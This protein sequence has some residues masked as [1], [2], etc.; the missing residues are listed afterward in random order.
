MLLDSKALRNLLICTAVSLALTSCA[1]W[2]NRYRP[3]DI[4]TNMPDVSVLVRGVQKAIDD[5][6]KHEAWAPND[7]FTSKNAICEAKRKNANEHETA[8]CMKAYADARTDC[9]KTMGVASP[10][11][12]ADYFRQ[13]TQ[14]CTAAAD[15]DPPE[16]AQ[17]KLIGPPRISEA[18]LQLTAV[19]ESGA[20]GSIELTL[21]S[22]KAS[23]K[24]GRKH[25]MEISL[26]PRPEM[27]RQYLD[28]AMA[29]QPP[30]GRERES[31][32]K[33]VYRVNEELRRLS[34][35]GRHI[36]DGSQV[37]PADPALVATLTQALTVALDASLV[38][39][40]DNALMRQL[41]LKRMFY[42]FEIDYSRELGGEFKWSISPISG[43][44]QGKSGGEAGNILTIEVVR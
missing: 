1:T 6:M 16:C 8:E 23:R 15:E 28:A 33:I 31:A 13:A 30:P 34:I 36:K 4:D 26:I 32:A 40:E 12:C 27:K 14:T 11:L 42:Q 17:A 35:E 39:S 20:G 37:A 19:A 44:V 38:D 18:K 29:S 41:T 43:T 25:T 10:S 7:L 3:V 5:T 2:N 9:Q 21:L 24:L 22:A